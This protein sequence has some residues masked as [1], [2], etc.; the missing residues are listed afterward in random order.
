MT[1]CRVQAKLKEE[2][3]RM[4]EKLRVMEARLRDRGDES[5]IAGEPLPVASSPR[6]RNGA[7]AV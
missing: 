5:D 6:A 4:E 1:H 2:Y 3:D 7:T